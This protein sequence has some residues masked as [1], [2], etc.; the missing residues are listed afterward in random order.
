MKYYLDHYE[1]IEWILNAHNYNDLCKNARDKVLRK[2]D[3]KIVV[4]KYINL[5]KDILNGK[6]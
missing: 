6:V 1:G 5:Y 2:Y 3:S 4:K